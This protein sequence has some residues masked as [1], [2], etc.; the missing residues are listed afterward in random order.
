[1]DWDSPLVSVSRER[2]VNE[3]LTFFRGGGVWPAASRH[4]PHGHSSLQLKALTETEET[5]MKIIATGYGTPDVLEQ[6]PNDDRRPDHG[7]VAIA[8]RAAGVN[9]RDYK[10]YSDPEYT[11]ARGGQDPSFPLEL[12]VEAAGVVTAVGRDASGPGG[13]IEVG[14]EVIA[15]R[16]ANGYADRIVAKAANVIPKPTRLT[17]EQAGSL[18]LA[19]TTAAHALAAV[20]ARPGQTV[21]VHA[22]AGGV[23]RF[24]V[25]LA[26]L[27]GVKVIGTAGEHDFDTLRG[28]GAV[29]VRYGDGLLERAVGAATDG[30][31][32]AIDLIGTDEAVDTSLELVQDR[33]R[34][35][36]IVAFERVRDT[37][38]QALGGS[39]GQDEEGLKIRDFARLRVTAL[40]QAGALEA[41]VA[42]SFPLDRAADAHRL[43]ADGGGG[44]RTVLLTGSADG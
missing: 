12:G 18:M 36:T 11:K 44:G 32:A 9:P 24:V 21:L 42:R 19:S 2:V 26:A 34:I 37:G 6:A 4:A 17:W 30:I 35:A 43:Y 25:Q 7:E 16:I 15:Y 31:D 29:P 41:G 5:N 23:G 14:D 13:P 20:R 27:E 10:V 8:V 28:F 38:I 33:S 3:L 1:M 39:P 40:A 22:A